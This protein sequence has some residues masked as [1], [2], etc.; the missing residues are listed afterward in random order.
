MTPDG[1]PILGRVP[2]VPNVWI[3]T[4]HGYVS[5]ER[6]LLMVFVSLFLATNGGGSISV[7]KSVRRWEP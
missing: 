3:A 4:G 7:D 2:R 5:S 6:E 1:L